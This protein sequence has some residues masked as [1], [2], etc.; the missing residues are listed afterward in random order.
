MSRTGRLHQFFFVVRRI[1]PL[2]VRFRRGRKQLRLPV[3]HTRTLRARRGRSHFHT[4]RPDSHNDLRQVHAAQEERAEEEEPDSESL[5]RQPHTQQQRQL[6]ARTERYFRGF[7]RC[8]TAPA[9]EIPDERARRPVHDGTP[10]RNEHRQE[11]Q[12]VLTTCPTETPGVDSPND[13][14]T[15]LI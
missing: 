12:L 7:Q 13:M 6:R 14:R 5:A 11:G 10:R 9:Q 8:R 4:L 15:K 2:S 1:S 3:R